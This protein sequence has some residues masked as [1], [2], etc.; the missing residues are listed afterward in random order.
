MDARVRD[1]MRGSLNHNTV[2]LDDRPQSIPAGPFHWRTRTDA[3]LHA[4]RHNPSFDWAEALHDGYAPVRHRRSLV[5][6]ADTGW[7]VVDEIIG[8]ERHSATAHWHFDPDWIL[9]SYESGQL[10][11]THVE[12]DVVWLLHDG[13]ATW[14][15]HGD[16]ESGLG[17]YAPA[18]GTLVPTWTAG[19]RRNGI[20]PFAMVTWIGATRQAFDRPPLLQRVV[21]ASDPGGTA[22]AARVMAGT[23]S[24]VFL[25]RPGE[26]PCRDDR[27][28]GV[29]DYQTNARVLHYVTDD[30]RVVVVD[31]ID[32]SHV[33]ALREGW[34]S[35]DADQPI[36]DLHAEIDNGTL[37]L[38]ASAPPAELRVQGSVV[39]TLRDIR[40]NGREL[41]PLSTGGDTLRIDGALWGAPGSFRL[42]A[43]GYGL[44]A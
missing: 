24:S 15:V 11:A 39:T 28:C 29:L 38:R 43:A 44:L 27:S 10:R 13:A 7:L 30:A 37:I 12:G 2:T 6:T 34:L 16:E 4:C 21:M 33:R 31:A 5:R 14:L 23:K 25:L 26:P 18:Y 32:A 1:R 17:W 41:P 40:V 36:A 20:A 22:I 42:Q 8:Q 9:T 3:R 19:I 35:L